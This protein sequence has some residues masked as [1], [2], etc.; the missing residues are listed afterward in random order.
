MTMHIIQYGTCIIRDA[1]NTCMAAWLGN[2]MNQAFKA[3][4]E[5]CSLHNFVENALIEIFNE[6]LRP[7]IKRICFIVDSRSSIS[8]CYLEQFEQSKQVIISSWFLWLYIIILT[9]ADFPDY[10]ANYAPLCW[11]Y[12]LC[13]SLPIMPA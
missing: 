7:T 1:V 12:A 4:K 5:I 3:I 10:A 11:H 8:N 2:D 6:K 13:F 9:A